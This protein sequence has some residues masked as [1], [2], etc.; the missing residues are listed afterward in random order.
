MKYA[1]GILSPLGFKEDAINRYDKTSYS[2]EVS[3]VLWPNRMSIIL[4]RLYLHRKRLGTN[5]GRLETPRFN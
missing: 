4:P 1:R 2:I 5:I 3:F